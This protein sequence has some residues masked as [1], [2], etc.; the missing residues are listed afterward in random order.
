MSLA[1]RERLGQYACLR[2][3]PAEDVSQF[4]HQHRQQVHP[5]LFALVPGQMEF[6][7]VPRRGVH[8]PSPTGGVVIQPLLGRTADI[9]GYGVSLLAGAIIQLASVPFLYL[10][11]RQNSPADVASGSPSNTPST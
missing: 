11:R 6:A 2:V 1:C 8:K 10:S 5:A 4:M 3:V 9:S 7:I